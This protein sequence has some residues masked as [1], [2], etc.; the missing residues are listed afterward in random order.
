MRGT[1]S[2]GF[3]LRANAPAEQ[4][5]PDPYEKIHPQTMVPHAHLLWGSVWAGIAAVATAKAQAFVR[6]A[7][8]A[9]GRA[10]AAGRARSSPG[11]VARCG[12][13]AACLNSAIR[14]YQAVHVRRKGAS[15][16]SNFNR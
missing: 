15:P 4:V 3:T 12:R 11:R 13:C 7:L 8:R 2:E 16:R 6:N 14:G 5:L 1:H 9:S 10:D